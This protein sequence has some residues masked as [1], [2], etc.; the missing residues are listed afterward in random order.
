[1]ISE[2]IR[3]ALAK[4]ISTADEWDYGVKKCWEEEI[5]I[6]SRNIE[7]TI[8]FFDHECTEDEFSWFSEVFYE[9]AEKTQSR[10]FIE[11]LYRVAKKYPE[12]CK[13]YNVYSFIDEAAEAIDDELSAILRAE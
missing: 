13:K 11:C 8:E 4:R 5:G 10:P 6:L 3:K 7:E 9:V 1:M 2:E 12:E